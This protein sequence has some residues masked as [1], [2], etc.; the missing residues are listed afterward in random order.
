MRDQIAATLFVLPFLSRADKGDQKS[1]ERDWPADYATA[2]F[3]TKN[4]ATA[5]IGVYAPIYETAAE[6]LFT[7]RFTNETQRREV[8]V[9]DDDCFW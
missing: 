5:F 2:A 3:D 1:L 4:K 8:P 9:H 7:S 6:N